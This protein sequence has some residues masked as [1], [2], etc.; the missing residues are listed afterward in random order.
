MTTL[1]F[2]LKLQPYVLYSLF[3]KILNTFL[4]FGEDNKLLVTNVETDDVT[5]KST[6]H[7]G[8][9]KLYKPLPDDIEK[10]DKA[11]IVR[12]ILP[13]LTETVELVPYDQED[14]DV[15]V[16]RVPESSNVDSPV[17]NRQTELK[18]YNDF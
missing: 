6:P 7:S 13:Q 10:G 15:L 3:S 9:F 11:F 5:F 14:E 4:H 2:S 1:S 16:L 12:E 17:T 8:I 18:S